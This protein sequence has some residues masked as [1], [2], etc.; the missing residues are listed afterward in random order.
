MLFWVTVFLL[1]AMTVLLVLEVADASLIMFGTLIVFM[2][3]GIVDTGEAFSGF[4]SSATLTIG[5]LYIIAYA[6]QSTGVLNTIGSRLLGNPHKSHSWR[7]MRLLFPVAAVSTVMNNTPI[8]AMLI[9]MVKRWCRLYSISPS[10]ILLLLSYATILGGMCTLIGTSTNLVVHGM[11]LEHGFRGF[12]FFGLGAVGLPLTIAGTLLCVFILHRWLPD[13]KEAIVSLGE[14][15]REFVV[16]LKVAESYS[17]INRSIEQ[18]GLRHLQ[19]L[20]LFQIERNGSIIAP[21]SPDDKIYLRDRLFFTGVPPTIVELQKE[22]GLEV[23]Q[24]VEFDIK[25]YDSHRYQTFEAVISTSSPLVG[26]RV[27]DSNFRQHYDAVI[28]GIHRNGHRINRKVGDIVLQEGDTLLILAPASFHDRW[29]H[30]SD[31]LLVSNSEQIP[32]RSKKHTYIILSIFVLMILSVVA[33]LL[34]MLLA[35]ATAVMILMLTRSITVQEA[36][37]AIN[38]KV[39][40]VIAASLGIGHAVANAGVAGQVADGLEALMGASGSPYLMISLM[41]LITMLYSELITNAAAAAILFPVA[42]SFSDGDI[43]KLMPLAYAVAIGASASFMT[44]IGYQTNLMVYGP[45]GYRFS[46]YSRV[47]FPLSILVWLGGS[48]IIHWIFFGL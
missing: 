31:F 25:N 8:V 4:S 41:M 34:P 23:V 44:P 36:I 24:G 12:T 29:Y 14:S 20:F 37:R 28:L 16:A 13:R 46:D 22:P 48:F 3:C 43:H 19:G 33:G 6:I 1:V 7:L 35:A 5:F 42:L 26:Q 45:G 47:G 30:S 27:R 17:H 9:P 39:L 38:W 11:L 40:L 21:V 32:S 18:A 2:L 15:T 10:R